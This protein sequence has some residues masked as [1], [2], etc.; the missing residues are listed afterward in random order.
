M[1]SPIHAPINLQ[2]AAPN[3]PTALTTPNVVK[4]RVA[5][6]HLSLNPAA[7]KVL[8]MATAVPML[9]LS[10]A[11]VTAA[12]MHGLSNAKAT[13]APMLSPSNAKATAAPVLS[14]S[15]RS[16]DLMGNDAMKDSAGPDRSHLLAV[17]SVEDTIA[18]WDRRS[19]VAA[20]ANLV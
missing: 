10:N 2:A 15:I 3:N 16:H 8:L 20:S 13:A 1:N 19:S 17:I 6:H 18:T 7:V 14:L 5:M 9:S 4:S 11:K 12:P